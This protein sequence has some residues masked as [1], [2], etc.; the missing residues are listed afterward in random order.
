MPSPRARPCGCGR[1]HSETDHEVWKMSYLEY[2]R[3]F[4]ALYNE[5]TE[6]ETEAEL[7]DEELEALFA[8]HTERLREWANK[9]ELDYIS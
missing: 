9:L 5:R 4:D 2:M 6:Y 3:A 1:D 7:E 8:E